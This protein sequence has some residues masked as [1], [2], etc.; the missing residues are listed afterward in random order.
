MD[1]PTTISEYQDKTLELVEA[2]C[3]THNAATLI[4]NARRLNELAEDAT[5]LANGLNLAV[6]YVEGLK[7]IEGARLN[8]FTTV[9]AQLTKENAARLQDAPK[10]LKW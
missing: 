7:A 9:V 2:S 8:G 10:W 3:D 6:Q 1:T 5:D 4:A